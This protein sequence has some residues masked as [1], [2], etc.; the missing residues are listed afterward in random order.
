M[1]WY[2]VTAAALAFTIGLVHSV[3]GERLIFRRMRSSGSIIPTE[4][5]QV[6]REA[7]VRILWASWHLVTVLGW[8]MAALLVWLALPSSAQPPALSFVAKAIAVSM[9]V[10]SLLIFIGTQGRH[11]GWVGLLAVAVVAG[12]GW[13]A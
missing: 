9:L 1:N 12:W 5:G 7:H 11:L 10:S 2:F 13:Q 3:L 4:G 6:L 8:C